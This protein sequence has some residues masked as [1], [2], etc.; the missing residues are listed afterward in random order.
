MKSAFLIG[1][2]NK[3]FT[4]MQRTKEQRITHLKSLRN[5][6]INSLPVQKKPPNQKH[7]IPKELQVC[8]WFSLYHTKNSA[9]LC[10]LPTAPQGALTEILSSFVRLSEFKVVDLR[11]KSNTSQCKP[12]ALFKI[13]KA[14]FCVEVVCSFT[15]LVTH[16][17][18][19]LVTGHIPLQDLGTLK[20]KKRKT[21]KQFC[22]YW[23]SKYFK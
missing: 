8:L 7:L 10:I 23:T 5:W 16:L 17:L 18:W 21:S 3:W 1:N 20:L 22:L 19:K 15:A 6:S 13:C 14:F 4:R 2:T 9:L 11:R 12:R